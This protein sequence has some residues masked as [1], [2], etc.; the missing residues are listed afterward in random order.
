MV[1]NG[2]CTRL[3]LLH[4]N[5]IHM[6]NNWMPVWNFTASDDAVISKIFR[7]HLKLRKSKTGGWEEALCE[8]ATLKSLLSRMASGTSL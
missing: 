4:R 6:T 1:R 7:A 3:T 8:M 5:F 2:I